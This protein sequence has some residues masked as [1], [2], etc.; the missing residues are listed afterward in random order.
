MSK[1]LKLETIKVTSF[2]TS[3][4]KEEAALIKGGTD[5]SGLLCHVTDRTW[6]GLEC[7]GITCA[8]TGCA[9]PILTQGHPCSTPIAT[10]EPEPVETVPEGCVPL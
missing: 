6:C 4:G 5:D 1:K 10:I 7:P 2:V 3:F 9:S 8:A